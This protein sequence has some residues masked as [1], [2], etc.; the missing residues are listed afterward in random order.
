MGSGRHVKASKHAITRS[1]SAIVGA[2]KTDGGK[3]DATTLVVRAW[4]DEPDLDLAN[5][6]FALERDLRTLHDAGYIEFSR[7]IDRAGEVHREE[8]V[9]A[10]ELD[11]VFPLNPLVEWDP[12]GHGFT[13]RVDAGY[14][15]RINFTGAGKAEFD[16]A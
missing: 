1:Q 14:Q 15:L 4:R 16:G 7:S 5:V 3:T 8:A 11:S 10:T 2:I 6:L 13:A 9:L 12:E